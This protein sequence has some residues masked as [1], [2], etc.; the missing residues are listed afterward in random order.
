MQEYSQKQSFVGSTTPR[1]D[2]EYFLCFLE[3]TGKGPGEGRPGIRVKSAD[4]QIYATSHVGRA[5]S[6]YARK[7]MGQGN[8][9]YS[10]GFDQVGEKWTQTISQLQEFAIGAI[11]EIYSSQQRAF[12][13][14]I[15]VVNDGTLWEVG[16]DSDM[17]VEY[18]PHLEEKSNLKFEHRFSIEFRNRSEEF[19]VSHLHITTI[20]GLPYLIDN[21]LE[22]RV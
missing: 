18:P 22:I 8:Y 16:Y 17:N 10:T 1:E 21:I 12:F 4:F 2:N 13:I 5:V 11:R 19:T 15:L 20:T 9:R 7:S 6:Q 14:P 3:H